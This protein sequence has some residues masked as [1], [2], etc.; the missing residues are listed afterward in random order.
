[1]MPV[2]SVLRV[3]LAVA[4][5]ASLLAIAFAATSAAPNTAQANAGR[6][7]AR[8]SLGAVLASPALAP[9]A[10]NTWTALQLPPFPRSG[11][12]SVWDSTNAQMLLF[13]GKGESNSYN[14]V[15]A[16]RPGSDSW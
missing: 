12:L 3:N 16:Y 1:M 7:R 10:I 8:D 9:A 11:H 14:D 5:L 4:V 13:G 2:S 15:W 6:G